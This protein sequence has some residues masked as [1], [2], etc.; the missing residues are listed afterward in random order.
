MQRHIA[1]LWDRRIFGLA[2]RRERANPADARHQTRA[3]AGSTRSDI[4][5]LGLDTGKFVSKAL[6]CKFEIMTG[7]HV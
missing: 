6:L 3:G 1:W 2:Y 4:P 5:R 7:L